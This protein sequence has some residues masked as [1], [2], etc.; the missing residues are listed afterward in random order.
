MYSLVFV[1]APTV[2]I[3]LVEFGDDLSGSVP[4]KCYPRP[5]HFQRRMLDWSHLED[6]HLGCSDLL[7]HRQLQL[8]RSEAGSLQKAEKCLQGRSLGLYARHIRL[9]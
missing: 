3:A 9:L 5:A 7:S 8:R 4:A 1:E 2:T 6:S